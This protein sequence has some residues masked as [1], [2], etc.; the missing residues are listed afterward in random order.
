MLRLPL[1]F[2]RLQAENGA[3]DLA[4]ELHDGPAIRRVGRGTHLVSGW[5]AARALLHDR[6]AVASAGE[7]ALATFP[8][9]PFRTHHAHTLPFMDTEDHQRVRRALAQYFTSGAVTGLASSIQRRASELVA[10]LPDRSPVELVS[11][12]SAKLPIEV[13]CEVLGLPVEDAELMADAATAVT[14]GLEPVASAADHQAGAQ[15]VRR[16]EA[17]LRAHLEGAADCSSLFGVL[18]RLVS[19]E[20]LSTEEMVHQ[21]IFLLNAGHETTTKL[22][23]AAIK[24]MISEPALIDDV[25]TGKIAPEAV[26]EECVRLEPSLQLAFRRALSPI[27]VANQN[28]DAGDRLVIFIAG[29]NRDP[30]QFPDPDRF[31]PG[32]QNLNTHLSFAGGP[33]MCLGAHLA[34][35]ETAAIISACAHEWRRIFPGGAARYTSGPVFFGLSELPA[36]IERRVDAEGIAT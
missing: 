16:V 27:E 5:A 18:A 36:R 14:R 10:D 21:A 19:E 2:E 4:R 1:L 9:G 35:L 29:A 25:R 20:K 13:I 30:S 3:R 24:R 7:H 17:H 12:L 8:E 15:A 28:I 23:A 11:L 33:H 26:A 22:I 6:A 31:D 32:R 34:R